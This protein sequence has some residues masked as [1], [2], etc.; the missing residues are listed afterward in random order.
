MPPGADE[1]VEPRA[2]HADRAGGRHD[3]VGLRLRLAADPAERA[4][5]GV[6]R[7]PVEG[8][9]V[10]IDEAVD[11]NGGIAA[12]GEFGAVAEDEFAEPAL[13]RADALV[14]VEPAT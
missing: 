14:A 7:Q 3:L 2:A 5:G 10:V 8:L 9:G 13:R 6:E 12:D 4:A 1:D 11:D